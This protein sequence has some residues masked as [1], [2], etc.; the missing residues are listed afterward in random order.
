MAKN[1]KRTARSAG[2]PKQK[3]P[4]SS[5]RSNYPLLVMAVG[6]VLLAGGGFFF[7]KSRAVTPVSVQ[8]VAPAV[9]AGSG[10]Q[11][12]RPT[13]PPEIFSGKVRQAYAI[14]RDIPQVLDKLYCYCRCRE[15]FGHKNLLSCYV[16]NHA[17]T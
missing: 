12:T 9:A 17:S 16:D 14:A 10:L 5:K 1:K 3:A 7:Y 6:A 2:P 13:L 15:N 8:A 4:E 11:E